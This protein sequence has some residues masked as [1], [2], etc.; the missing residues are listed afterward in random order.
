M[1]SR[2]ALV[3]LH[4]Y[5]AIRVAGEQGNEATVRALEAARAGLSEQLVE[6]GG[7]PAGPEG[8]PRAEAHGRGG[9]GTRS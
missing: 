4:S 1:R 9:V 3:A 2:A 7:A 8:A 5:R 6:L